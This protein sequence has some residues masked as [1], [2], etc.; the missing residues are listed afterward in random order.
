MTATDLGMR[1]QI[2][3]QTLSPSQQW[4]VETASVTYLPFSS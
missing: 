4:G 1:S 3:S 2:G